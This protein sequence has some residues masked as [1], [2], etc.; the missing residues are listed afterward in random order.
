MNGRRVWGKRLGDARRWNF[1][2]G[3]QLLLFHPATIPLSRD[4]STFP[5]A[6][7]HGR[8]LFIFMERAMEEI[9]DRP[10]RRPA[11]L[12]KPTRPG[13]D[14]AKTH[15]QQVRHA[16]S[17]LTG[18]GIPALSVSDAE[19]VHRPDEALPPLA[20]FPGV[21]DRADAMRA[22]IDPGLH[23]AHGAVAGTLFSPSS[24]PADGARW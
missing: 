12:G 9:L 11:R 7:L 19:L 14:I 15:R 8:V 2:F 1:P 24:N 5:S 23:R 17:W 13:A 6:G 10:D 3:G 21:P 20:A 4:L 22:V 18:R 16:K